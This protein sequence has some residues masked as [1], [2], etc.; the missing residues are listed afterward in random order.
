MLLTE[1]QVWK[2]W[3]GMV[4]SNGN[5]VSAFHQLA[6]WIHSCA[7]WLFCFNQPSSVSK[8]SCEHLGKR[9]TH[10]FVHSSSTSGSFHRL[11]TIHKQR[12]FGRSIASETRIS[13][14]RFQNWCDD[15]NSPQSPHCSERAFSGN[16]ANIFQKPQRLNNLPSSAMGIA[17]GITSLQASIPFIPWHPSWLSL[18]RS[19]WIQ[20]CSGPRGFLLAGPGELDGVSS[21]TRGLA[22]ASLTRALLLPF[23]SPASSDAGDELR[24]VDTHNSHKHTEDTNTASHADRHCCL[25]QYRIR[26]QSTPQN[27]GQ[28]SLAAPLW[29]M[30]TDEPCTHPCSLWS[31]HPQIHGVLKYELGL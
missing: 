3:S 14:N 13:L 12:N 5:C 4:I 27:H 7:Y 28:P 21:Q 9:E 19:S 8:S 30:L 17:V 15:R 22:H 20:R 25:Y 18:L 24:E 2:I 16:T 10:G 11:S 31:Q 26:P 23:A 29:R 1:E 6:A